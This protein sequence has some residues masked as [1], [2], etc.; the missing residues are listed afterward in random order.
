MLSQKLNIYYRSNKELTRD[1]FK[2]S[3]HAIGAGIV[4]CEIQQNSNTTYRVYDFHRK[5]AQGNLRDLHVEKA[6]DVSTL[7]PL[8]TDFSAQ[9]E[10]EKFEDY[11]QQVLVSCP[12][13]TTKK[14]EVEGAFDHNVSKESFEAII[15]LEGALSIKNSDTLI[16]LK[17][18]ESCF[19]DA[20][21]SGLQISGKASFLAVTV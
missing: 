8:D 6:L 12:Y 18:G 1:D 17:K 5:D 7:S 10:L 13:F 14:Y 15:V 4:I 11:T 9:G 19:I 16:D 3:I 20:D 2:A 21:T